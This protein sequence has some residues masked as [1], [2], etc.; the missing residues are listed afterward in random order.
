M[1]R[2]RYCIGGISVWLLSAALLSFLYL[3]WP[4]FEWMRARFVETGTNY[5]HGFLIPF[6]SLWLVWTKRNDL[7]RTQAKS[8]ATGLALLAFFL[9]LHYLAAVL[10]VHF[11]SGLAVVGTCFALC[12]TFWGAQVTRLLRF[13][14]VFLLFA[15]PLPSVMLIHVSFKLK[16]WAATLATAS[17]TAMGVPAVQYGALIRLPQADV[18][19]DDPCSGLRS[20]IALLALGALTT[21]I[22]PQKSAWRGWILFAS[23]IPIALFTNFLRVVFLTLLTFVYGTEAASGWL[24]DASGFMVFALAFILLTSIGHLLSPQTEAACEANA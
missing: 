8:S 19:V 15:V 2:T 6:V 23:A 7:A 3:Y 20:L 14:I 24:H 18:L 12:L 17:V 5:S 11:V 9:I 4:T 21:Q 1:T 10:S 16:M 22:V 13:P